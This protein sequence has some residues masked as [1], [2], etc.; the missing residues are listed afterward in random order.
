MVLHG[1]GVG[2]GSLVYANVLVEPDERLFEAP[3]WRRLEDWKEVLQPYFALARAM[4]GVTENPRLTASD[5]AVEAVANSMGV[6]MTFRPTQ[7]GVYFGEEDVEVGDPYFDGDG[8][9]RT[10]CNHCGAC[11]VGCRTNAKN[12]LL[13]NYLYFAEKWGAEIKPETT[14]DSIEPL[15]VED[16][17][18]ARYQ[19]HLADTT[20][21]PLKGRQRIRARNVVVSAGV[22][23]TL[24]GAQVRSNSEALLGATANHRDQD[25]T[26]G[27]A[28]GSVFQAD[29]VTSVEPFHYPAGSSMMYRILGAPMIDDGGRGW[30]R[31]GRIAAEIA[32]HPIRFLASK[33]EP[34]WGDRTVGLLV[35]QTEENRLTLKSGR[36]LFTLFRRGLVSARDRARPIPAEIPIG[37]K[38]TRAVASRIGGVALG[39]VME[40]LLGAPITAH[41][42]GGC[43]MGT[44]TEDGVVDT[45]CRVF[46]Y[47]GMYVVDGSIVPANPG[48]NPSLTITALA[49]YAMSRIAPSNSERKLAPRV[50]RFSHPVE[51]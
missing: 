10:G 36:D 5:R 1:S 31:L 44:S 40:G 26:L 35:M 9:R 4:L 14:V 38:V 41:P 20:D 49:E 39:N 37:H 33:F 29:D 51:A 8:P 42:L 45:E 22:V 18:G 43:P 15:S 6:G 13:K 11:M 50:V 23:G 3:D 7:V 21:W 24:L 47:P 16:A 27:I 2:G 28:I 19:L 12:V 25:M 48:M 46:N 32:R 34:G 17:D 30:P